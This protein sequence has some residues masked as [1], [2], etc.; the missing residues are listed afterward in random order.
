MGSP[1][2]PLEVLHLSLSFSLSLHLSIH[3]H[4]WLPQL[5]SQPQLLYTSSFQSSTFHSLFHFTITSFLSFF[6]IIFTPAYS[7][8]ISIFFF[9]DSFLERSL[10]S[11]QEI[12]KPAGFSSFF[13]QTHVTRCYCWC[14]IV[15][16]LWCLSPLLTFVPSFSFVSSKAIPNKNARKG[17]RINLT[18]CP[19]PSDFFL[20]DH[21]H[22]YP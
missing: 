17:K 11:P 10:D 21:S 18:H 19:L 1:S 9:A 13:Q 3:L 6:F 22:S 16:Y 7:F 5:Q 14:I 2:L 4:Y 15:V 12:I 20:L 8:P